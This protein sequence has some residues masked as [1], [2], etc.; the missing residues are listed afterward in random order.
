M[1]INNYLVAGI[2]K[3]YKQNNFLIIIKILEL[4]KF[5][6]LLINSSYFKYINIFVL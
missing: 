1:R 6:Q 3:F 5:N 2:Y 4:N